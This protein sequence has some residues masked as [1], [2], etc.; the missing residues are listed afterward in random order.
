MQKTFKAVSDL[1]VLGLKIYSKEYIVF[2]EE[3][4][5]K[6]KPSVNGKSVSGTQSKQTANKSQSIAVNISVKQ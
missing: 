4:K 6:K 1:T 5:T 3:F 2:E